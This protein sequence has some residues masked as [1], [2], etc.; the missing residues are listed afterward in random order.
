[1]GIHRRL[2]FVR[3]YVLSR[4]I[5]VVANSPGLAALSASADPVAVTFIPNGVDLERFRPPAQ[6]PLEPFRFLF[7]GRLHDQKNVGLL[8]EAAAELSRSANR[9]FRVSI[10]GDGPLRDSLRQR[11]AVLQ[12]DGIVDWVDWLPRE[13]MPAVYQAA[14][15]IVNPSHYEGMPNVVLEAMACAV[16]VIVSNV[17]GNRDLVQAGKG[18]WVVA[19][20]SREELVEAM[21]QALRERPHLDDRGASARS[22]VA[23]RF[24]WDAT[25]LQYIDLLARG[26]EPESSR[27]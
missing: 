13:Q 9:P 7:A 21:A 23:E 4:A 6:R 1:M 17:A 16:P 10:V 2:R 8:L 18:G 14:H 19:V 11:A 15:C 12:L 27:Y 22:F 5:A 20:D 24:S 3:R 26:A 25:T